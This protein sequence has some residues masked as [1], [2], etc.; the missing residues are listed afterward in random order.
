MAI[1]SE[2]QKRFTSGLAASDYA[3]DPE[4]G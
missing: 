1:T 3:L 2:V 4:R